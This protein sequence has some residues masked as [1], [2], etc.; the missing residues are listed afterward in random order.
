MHMVASPNRKMQR[1]LKLSM[2]LTAAY[3]VATFCFGVRAHSLALISEAGHNVSDLLAI[4]LSFAAV[5]FQTRPATDQKTFGYQRAGVLA[6][7][8]NALTLI[9]LAAWIAL[10][11]IHRLYAP[12]PVQPRIM[13]TV[14][15]AG[16]LMNGAIAAML[17]KSSGDVNIRTVF[18]HMLGDTL[19]T[20]AVIA[21]GAGILVTGAFWLDPALSLFIAAMIAWSS[22]SIVRETLNILLE[23]TPRTLSLAEIR[24][25]VGGVSG[26]LD[27]HDLHV[28]SLGSSSHALAS[29]V[30]IGEMPIS[31]SASILDAI[32]C[33]LRDRFHI[34]HTTIQFEIIGCET[35]HGCSA[36]PDP[37]AA[38]AHHGHSHAH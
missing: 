19:S 27:V 37:V 5:Y 18:L 16:V 21:G 24:T 36:P 25:A 29:H 13:M 1:V 10:S 12:V 2:A 20:A 17:W 11:A 34:T 22:S 9:V 35:T 4:L 3:V 23:G 31:G 6:A 30:T 15:A 26:V 28:W 14:A 8:I 7:F 38:H 32:N 33:A